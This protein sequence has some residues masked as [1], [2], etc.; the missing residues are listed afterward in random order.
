MLLLWNHLSG[1]SWGE[2]PLVAADT[3]TCFTQLPSRPLSAVDAAKCDN[4]MQAAIKSI[5][6]YPTAIFIIG[7]G[8]CDANGRCI[9]AQLA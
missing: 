7:K 4:L 1:Y 8:N 6:L 3:L 9:F 5:L 2:L